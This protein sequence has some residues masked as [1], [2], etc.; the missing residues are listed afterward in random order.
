[1]VI[2]SRYSTMSPDL[3][4]CRFPLL[5]D[6]TA[7]RNPKFKEGS[8]A[9]HFYCCYTGERNLGSTE[10]LKA[11]LGAVALSKRKLEINPT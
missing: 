9:R 11:T 5:A 3:E 1:M 2:E 10:L 7:L 4:V 6:P 8:R